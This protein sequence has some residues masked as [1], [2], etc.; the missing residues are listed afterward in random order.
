MRFRNFGVFFRAQFR[1]EVVAARESLDCTV[2]SSL[3]IQLPVERDAVS[4]VH[5]VHCNGQL[6]R[7]GIIGKR[8]L[9]IVKTNPRDSVV[10]SSVVGRRLA[11]EPTFRQNVSLISALG[12]TVEQKWRTLINKVVT[13]DVFTVQGLR[14]IRLPV[15]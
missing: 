1:Q 3:A 10:V 5:P 4:P 6:A 8:W 2:D 13:A 9:F 12:L 14:A 15:M 11:I 7:A